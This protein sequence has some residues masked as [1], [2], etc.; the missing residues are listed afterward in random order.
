MIASVW[1][2]GMH[3]CMHVCMYVRT[4]ASYNHGKRFRIWG[5]G[6]RG[7]GYARWLLISMDP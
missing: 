2:R 4:K 1:E 3:V 7:L 6:L 5:L